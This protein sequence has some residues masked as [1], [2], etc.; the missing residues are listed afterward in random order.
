MLAV[1][2]L[3]PATFDNC[4]AFFDAGLFLKYFAFALVKK[5]LK[6]YGEIDDIRALDNGAWIH[7]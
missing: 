6:K 1:T 4:H 5:A 2:C 3:G 7:P